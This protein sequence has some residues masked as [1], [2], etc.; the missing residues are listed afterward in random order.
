RGLAAWGGRQRGRARPY[1]GGFAGG[2]AESLSPLA[3][4]ASLERDD[5]SSNRHPALPFWWSMIFFRKPVPT[6]DQV[7]GRLFRDHAL[8]RRGSLRARLSGDEPPPIFTVR[9]AC[10]ADI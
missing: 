3:R 8:T 4:E 1:R 2:D 6:P 9:R 5:F 10:S 7:R